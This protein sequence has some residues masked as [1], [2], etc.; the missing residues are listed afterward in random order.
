MDKRRTLKIGQLNLAG[1]EAATKELP[2]IAKDHDLDLLLLQEQYPDVPEIIQGTNAK[3]GICLPRGDLPC[4][5]LHHL[6]TTHCIVV[7]IEPWDIYVVTAY[8]QYSDDIATHLHQLDAVLHR[9]RGKH[10]LIGVDSNAHSPM[11][12]CQERQYTGRGAAETRKRQLMEDFILQHRLTIHNA[13]GEPATFS[14][15]NGES[16]VDLTLS[17]RGVKVKEWRVHDGASVSD[18]RLITYQIEGELRPTT[19]R[20]EPSV[21]PKRFRERGVDWELFES[22][23][24]ESVG[25]LNLGKP[26]GA[27]CEDFSRIIDRVAL[28]ILGAQRSK[29]DAGYEWWTPTLD[30]LRRE[31]GRARR[32]WQGSRSLGGD[33]E[34][35]AR[36]SFRIARA[37]YR[38]AMEEAEISFFRRIAES[39]NSDPWGQAYRAASGRFRPPRSVINGTKLC[40]GFAESVGDSMHGLM[41]ALCPDDDPSRDT[42]HHRQIR[43]LAACIPTGRDSPPLTAEQL[44]SI[45]RGLPNTAPGADGVSARMLR[46]I[47][48]SASSELTYIM[49]KCVSEGVFPS[50]WKDGQLLVLPKGNGKPLSDPKAYRPIT[51]LPV[52]GKVLERV[53][54]KCAPEI[55]RGI[56]DC[57]H[58][59][60]PG[61]S[62]S[63]A[64]ESIISVARASSQKYVQAIFLDI[65]GAFD[66]AWWPMIM[67]KAKQGGS[68]PNIYRM[69]GDYFAGRR[70][71]MFVG[72]RVMWK[73]S[74][75]GCPQGSV[76]GPTLWN[77]LLDDLLR[78]PLP[79]GTSMVAYAD[80]VTILIEAR[81]RADIEAKAAAAMQLVAEWGVRNR[82]GFSP[83]K[84]AMMTLKG[85]FQKGRPPLVRMGGDSIKS[86]TSAT[87]LGVVID[88][89]LSFAQHAQSIGERAAKCFGK[90]ARVSATSWG[91]RYRA[92]K[93][94]YKGTFVATITYA[95]SVWFERA[96]LHIAR[97]PLLRTQRPAL[98]ML[99]KAYRSTSTAALSVLAG[100]LPADL[101][102]IRAGRVAVARKSATKD[103]F[104]VRRRE[105]GLDIVAQWQ[106]RWDREDKGRELYRFFPDVSVRLKATW[107]EPDYVTSQILVGHG[108]FRKRLHGMGLVGESGCS[109]GEGEE[110]L[111]HILWCCPL[112]DTF[113]QGMLSSIERQEEGP[114]Y[115]TDL[116]S[117]EANYRRLQEFARRWHEARVEEEE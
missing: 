115:Y 61:R 54:L 56:S 76:L 99:T 109:C 77:V 78:L 81:A 91:V 65:S 2:S 97:S 18:H 95:A 4:A 116:V 85:K 84:S 83:A 110:D 93:V 59:F 82:L 88:D 89:R 42:A 74:T 23:I 92:L 21:E 20:A 47:W 70:V 26:A 67:L 40:E 37:K 66:N 68:P 33:K 86:V 113:R 17:T 101:E 39:G 80:D 100:V 105:I 28:G 106:E 94:L 12:Y 52:L 32:L 63:T 73:V 7:H 31:H 58:G 98:T 15:S 25:D 36:D 60:M 49:G 72:D 48:C 104:P 30:H 14:T 114:V 43:I 57:Q 44:A 53:M 108:C 41:H 1:S 24:H 107:V 103:E 9:L 8:F 111:H 64:L 11:W 90:V 35:R 27:L 6:S 29:R 117:S 10:I 62:T 38:R 3:A 46:H 19:D 96:S 34:S 13:E 45:I 112:Y 102:V 50:V 55:G 51:L 22:S 79:E 87:V 5:V 16:N 71:G 75:M 69:L